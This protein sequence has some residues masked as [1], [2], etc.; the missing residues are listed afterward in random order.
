MSRHERRALRATERRARRTRG[1]AAPR[2][3]PFEA[4]GR[5]AREILAGLRPGERMLMAAQMDVSDRKKLEAH[6]ER[7]TPL[8]EQLM[9]AALQW[10]R[11][12][13]GARLEWA[14]QP[15]GQLLLGRPEL[16]FERLAGSP[17]ARQLL[18]AI[19]EETD[20]QASALALHC[21][22]GGLGWV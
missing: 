2:G 22:L 4:S 13:P 9:S 11:M 17:D 5:E 21:A 12:H 1:M 16:A 3:I 10:K 18:E 14:A 6:V 20:H 7:M 8:I 15:K 19:D